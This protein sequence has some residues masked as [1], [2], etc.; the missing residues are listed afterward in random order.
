MRRRLDPLVIFTIIGGLVFGL[1][2]YIS[3]AP[4]PDR[5]IVVDRAALLTFI[6][7]R[8]RAFDEAAAAQIFEDLSEED[9]TI[10]I[11]DY[12][13][14]EMLFREARKMG[15]A[16][17]DY[18][19]RRRLVQKVEFMNQSLVQVAPPSTEDLEK[20]WHVYQADFKRPAHISF[21]HVFRT[22]RPDWEV[23]KHNLTPQNAAER[24]ELFPYHL[25]YSDRPLPVIQGD[26]GAAFA[27]SIFR[28]DTPL[29][30]W[31]GP[32]TSDHGE[33]LVWVSARTPEYHPPL[34]EKQAEVAAAWSVAEKRRQISEILE[35]LKQYY[36]IDLQLP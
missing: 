6:Q 21:V 32:I 27:A 17:N 34:A 14:E 13:R 28:K 18:V 30:R 11:D 20:Y 4:E 2:S 36:T 12:I 24:S 7:F 1:V 33:H 5:H 22:D 35:R 8:M 29:E 10:L 31:V 23:L 3:P 15:F 9:Q 16:D 26:F 25:S 19:I